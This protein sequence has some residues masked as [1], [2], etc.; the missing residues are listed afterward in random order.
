M[1][2]KVNGP[3]SDADSVALRPVVDYVVVEVVEERLDVPGTVG[4][5]V[6]EVR[7]LVDVERDKRR[8]VPDRERVLGV[9]DVV[10]Q[11]PLV[12]VVRGPCPAAATH[13]R[14]LQVGLPRIERS[15]IAL[16]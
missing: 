9:A 7:V 5:E 2:A 14:G 12:P 10:E 4:A 6:D 15:E 16:D 11:A 13:A 3:A 8:R 1:A